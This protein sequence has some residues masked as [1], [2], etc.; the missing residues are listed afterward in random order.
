MAK[1]WMELS[2]F[3]F[4]FFFYSL[5]LRIGE[6][7]F[8][9]RG[10]VETRGAVG[11]WTGEEQR[12]HGGTTCTSPDHGGSSGGESVPLQRPGVATSCHLRDSEGTPGAPIGRGPRLWAGVYMQYLSLSEG[13]ISAPEGEGGWKRR[14]CSVPAV[15]AARGGWLG[16]P[17]WPGWYGVEA[18]LEEK[19]GPAR[20]RRPARFRQQVLAIGLH[21]VH[22]MCVCV[23]THTPSN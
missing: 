13:L 18:A 16:W 11:G 12:F 2:N 7:R 9:R 20:H 17:G 10:S 3:F 23:C 5:P 4:F 15:G 1:R 21:T 14:I 8:Q 22:G 6:R 19:A